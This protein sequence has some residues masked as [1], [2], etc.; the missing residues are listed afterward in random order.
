VTTGQAGCSLLYIL[1][2]E[3]VFGLNEKLLV[4]GRE[5]E[6]GDGLVLLIRETLALRKPAVEETVGHITRVGIHILTQLGVQCQVEQERDQIEF[7]RELGE[8]VG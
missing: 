3:L 2:L 1:Q 6:T 7:V 5:G 8:C 4:W